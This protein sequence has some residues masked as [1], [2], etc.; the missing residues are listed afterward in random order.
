MADPCGSVGAHWFAAVHC[1]SSAQVYS[2]TWGEGTGKLT[3]S[4]DVVPKPHELPGSAGAVGVSGAGASEEGVLV[5]DALCTYKLNRWISLSVRQMTSCKLNARGLIV[6]HEDCW[7][8]AD[9]IEH[10]PL[11][12][13]FYRWVQPKVG[14][15][16]S[17]WFLWQFRRAAA[18]TCVPAGAGQGLATNTLHAAYHPIE[19]ER[20]GKKALQPHL[21]GAGKKKDAA[22]ASGEGKEL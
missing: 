19:A 21:V 12:G 6:H 20:V 9:S 18:T 4:A 10:I 3:A 15:V 5:I 7:S 8:L 22:A 13:S 17:R 16:A 1:A 14:A 2:V 11:V